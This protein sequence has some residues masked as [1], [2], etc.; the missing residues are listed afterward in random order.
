MSENNNYFSI[1]QW[2]EEDRPRE[3]L[4]LKGKQALSHAELIAILIGSGS[5]NLSAVELSKQILSSYDNDLNVLG[6]LSIKDFQKFKGIGEAKAIT[7]IAA[8]ELGRRRQ[9]TDVKEKPKITSSQDAY[10]CLYGTMEDLNHE[11]F[12]ILILN[13]NNRVT[14]IEDISAGGVAG[15]VVDPKIIFKK[16]LDANASSIILSH[17]H[18]SGNLKPSKADIDVTKKI[19]AAGLTLEIRVLDHIIISEN[20]YYSFLDEGL[21]V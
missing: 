8:L 9:L 17:N 14:K 11:V 19:A 15:T 3:K 7:I 13:R 16:A 2:A 10:N 20:G 5:T 4:I 6:R 1:K 18:P 12:K 21:M